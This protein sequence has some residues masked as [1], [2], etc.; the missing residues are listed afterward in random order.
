MR[1]IWKFIL[2]VPDDGQRVTHLGIPEGGQVLT[3]QVK[4]REICM[5]VLVDPEAKRV[6]KRFVVWWTGFLFQEST[7]VRY[8][9]TVQG[10]PLV[11][12][13]FE[14]PDQPQAGAE[15]GG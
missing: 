10:G 14:V 13:V 2:D 11:Y 5:W 12:H 6:Q 3:A 4:D 9:A 15:P 7:P 8:V 1:T